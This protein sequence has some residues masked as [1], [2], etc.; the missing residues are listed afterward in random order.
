MYSIRTAPRDYVRKTSPESYWNDSTTNTINVEQYGSLAETWWYF[1]KPYYLDD[2]TIFVSQYE[3][4]GLLLLYIIR[5]LY[6]TRV[7]RTA[8]VNSLRSLI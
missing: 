5:D 2:L 1:F 8:P 3:P 7:G 4:Q 6:V